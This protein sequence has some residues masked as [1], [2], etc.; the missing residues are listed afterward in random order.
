MRYVI[1]ASGEKEEFSVKKFTNSLLRSGAT[2]EEVKKLIEDVEKKKDLKTT[3]DI[4]RYALNYLKKQGVPS[5]TRYNLKSALFQLGPSG[6]P[7][8]KFVARIFDKLEYNTLV[9]EKI[10][11]KCVI[12]EVDVLLKKNNK[13]HFVECKFHNSQGIKSGLK[14]TLYIR[15]RL[16]DIQA[17]SVNGLKMKSVFA[18]TNTKFTTDAIQ[19]ANC[20]G[21]SVIDWNYPRDGSLSVLIDKFCLH[22]ITSLTSLNK[23]QKKK[24]LRKNIILC[25]ELKMKPDVLKGLRIKTGQMKLIVKELSAICI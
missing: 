21:M 13:N 17:N 12:H 4:Y 10:N 15:A 25:S 24:L 22:P 18:V 14:I 20:V 11:G 16:E 6:Y 9:G 3:R 5:A 23:G 2:Q 7:F 19:Y 1:K 8:E